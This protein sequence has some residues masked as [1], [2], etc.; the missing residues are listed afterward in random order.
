MARAACVRFTLGAMN[1]WPVS[2]PWPGLGR[3]T[4]WAAVCLA[5]SLLVGCSLLTLAY[6]RLPTIAYW[7]LDAML[8]LSS[9]QSAFVRQEL[10]RWHAWHRRDHLPRY[11]QALAPWQNQVLQDVTP[12]QVCVVVDQLR[13]WAREVTQQALP[14][15]V[16]LT[17]SLT[18]AQLQHW[19]RHQAES[20]AEF[21]ADF[22]ASNGAVAPKRLQRA[23]ERA[24]MIYGTLTA[25]QQAWWQE[26][27]R[28]SSFDPQRSLAQRQQRFLDWSGV[29]RRIRAGAHAET[30]VQQAWQRVWQP[31]SPAD[32]AYRDAV[33][34]DGCALLA[35]WH[36]RTTHAQRLTAQQKLQSYGADFLALAGQGL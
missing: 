27:L 31:D 22:M 8:D 13:L 6:N 12:A 16:R 35:E 14:L 29:V 11:A 17:P 18:E 28:R 19:Q 7:R 23:I 26:R 2:H 32:A 9:A 21:R 1:A 33:Q 4:R 24:E 34:Q 30:E 10:D 36:N 25:E 15:A 5:V 3:L 20:G